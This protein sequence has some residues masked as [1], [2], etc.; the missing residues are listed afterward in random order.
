MPQFLGK[1]PPRRAPSPRHATNVARK[2]AGQICNGEKGT[3][4]ISL[5]ENVLDTAWLSPY[6]SI[7]EFNFPSLNYS[8]DPLKSYGVNA[9]CRNL[10]K[11]SSNH[12]WIPLFW[13]TFPQHTS[14][15]YSCHKF[16]WRFSPK[17]QCIHPRALLE[18]YTRYILK[19]LDLWSLTL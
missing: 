6:K 9:N 5:H 14:H 15:I 18:L 2:S 16:F 10:Q 8:C 12:S 7:H 1:S 11:I 4:E 17:L 13:H 3:S 19:T